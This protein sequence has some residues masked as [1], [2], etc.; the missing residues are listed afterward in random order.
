MAWRKGMSGDPSRETDS[1][2]GAG[3]G[4]IK[5][6]TIEGELVAKSVATEPSKFHVGDRVFRNPDEL[7]QLVRR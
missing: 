5:G 3:R 6:R 4:S 1:G 7:G 2:F